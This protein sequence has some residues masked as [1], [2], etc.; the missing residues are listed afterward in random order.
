[1]IFKRLADG[2]RTRDWFTVFVELLIVVVGIYLGLQANEWAQEREYRQQEQASLVRLLEES[3]AAIAGIDQEIKYMRWLNQR[4][5]EAVAMID[6]EDP[7]P[8][9]DLMLRTGINTLDRFPPLRPVTV[10]YDELL[11]AGQMQLIRS[12]DLRATI[13]TYHAALD[14]FNELAGRFAL[15]DGDFWSAYKRHVTWD[16]NPESETSDIL[17][18]SYDWKTLR[19][20]EEFILE[21]IGK[22]RNQLVIE[23][24]LHHLREDAVEMCRAIASALG[25]DCQH[26]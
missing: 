13:A 21:A 24:A 5:R 17:L 23:D 10:A 3:E 8:D 9:D 22:L 11:S 16:Y 14:Y 19:E 26:N 7:V 4:R 15:N 6:S 12:A 25:R 1:M 18:S 20:D 2:L